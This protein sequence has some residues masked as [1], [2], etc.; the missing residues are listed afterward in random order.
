M[1]ETD[2]TCDCVGD[3]KAECVVLDLKEGL[4]SRQTQSRD[5]INPGWHSPFYLAGIL[6]HLAPLHSPDWHR[7]LSSKINSADEITQYKDTW[8]IRSN[9]DAHLNTWKPFFF[10]CGRR[11]LQSYRIKELMARK[12]NDLVIKHA[13]YQIGGEKKKIIDP[14][15]DNMSVA[16]WLEAQLHAQSEPYTCTRKTQRLA[17]ALSFIHLS[18]LFTFHSIAACQWASYLITVWAPTVNS[19][20]TASLEFALVDLRR[21]IWLSP[22]IGHTA[23]L[24]FA[25]KNREGDGGFHLSRNNGRLPRRRGDTPECLMEKLIMASCGWTGEAPPTPQN[26][27]ST[28]GSMKLHMASPFS[29]LARSVVMHSH[30]QWDHG[31]FETSQ[32]S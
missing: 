21:P 17:F 6:T 4:C 1:L 28:L 2:Q 10:F 24:P 3:T 18:A 22:P 5:L 30:V 9:S 15:F 25:G 20:Y 13:E 16:R 31:G 29:G 26:T 14:I 11:I 8:Q 23:Y 27:S 12:E 19:E 32:Y 7:E